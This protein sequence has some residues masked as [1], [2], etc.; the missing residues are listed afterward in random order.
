MNVRGDAV[1]PTLI[2]F[3]YAAPKAP[4]T[5]CPFVLQHL[6]LAKL[7]SDKML[8]VDPFQRKQYL[9]HIIIIIFRHIRAEALW[10]MRVFG[11]SLSFWWRQQRRNTGATTGN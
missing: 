7:G 6:C 3:L 10:N 4:E 5:F 11:I 8:H 1:N 2:L 9:A